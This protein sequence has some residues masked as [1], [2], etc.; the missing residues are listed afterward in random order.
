MTQRRPHSASFP[1][2]RDVAPSPSNASVNSLTPANSIAK[3]EFQKGTLAGFA[4]LVVFILIWSLPLFAVSAVAASRG[5][6]PVAWFVLSFLM[7][8]VIAGLA[9]LV[10]PDFKAMELEERR[11]KEI[12]AAVRGGKS[13]P[14]DIADFV[15]R[16][17]AGK[18]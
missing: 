15:A 11:H 16:A 10:L 6:S 13:S 17:K 3:G 14:E 5:R 4:G 12:L 2:A 18:R 1:M 7:S 8:P 9:L